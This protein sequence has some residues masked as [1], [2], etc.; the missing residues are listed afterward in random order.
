MNR[1]VT[2]I[3]ETA[4][5]VGHAQIQNHIS[6]RERC[7]V[8]LHGGGRTRAAACGTPRTE[9]DP[10]G[11]DR[12]LFKQL[13]DGCPARDQP[14]SLDAIA[15]R[16]RLR[17][18]GR[19]EPCPCGSG[20]KYKKCCLPR[21]EELARGAAAGRGSESARRATAPGEQGAGRATASRSPGGEGDGPAVAAAPQRAFGGGIALPGG[22]A[23]ASATV[24]EATVSGDA[25]SAADAL[26][27]EFERVADPGTEQMTHARGN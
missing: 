24:D 25:K 17:R 7:R 5:I 6:H 10:A 4:L 23:A 2:L 9:R 19:N 16:E 12:L 3:T 22:A 20:R 1:L 27:D 8:Q 21:D 14:A 11:T 13:I 15:S 18:T 26:W